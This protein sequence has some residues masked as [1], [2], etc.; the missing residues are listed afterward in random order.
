MN[1]PLWPT[2]ANW[3]R[4]RFDIK[5]V[6]ECQP[7][8]QNDLELGMSALQAFGSLMSDDERKAFYS[9][10]EAYHKEQKEAAL[11]G[12]NRLS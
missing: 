10:I 3:L 11:N 7:V 4:M 6:V 8:E 2:L 9:D 12:T 1:E 5:S